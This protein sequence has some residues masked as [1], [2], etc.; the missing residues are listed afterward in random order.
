M[1]TGSASTKT[2]LFQSQLVRY[3]FDMAHDRLDISSDPERS[4]DTEKSAGPRRFLGVQFACCRVYQRV[5]VNREG[6]AYVGNCP[7]C[8]KHVWFRIGAGGT[9]ERFFTAY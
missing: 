4:E 3:F 1:T 6:T 9:D 7:R 8:G 5:Y 2:E